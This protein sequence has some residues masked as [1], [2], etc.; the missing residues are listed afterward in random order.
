M[1]FHPLQDPEI[2]FDTKE[3]AADLEIAKR[4]QLKLKKYV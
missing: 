2:W 1:S 4:D 3:I